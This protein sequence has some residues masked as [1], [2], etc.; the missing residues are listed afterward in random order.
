MQGWADLSD[1]DVLSISSGP[2]TARINPQGAELWSLTDAGDREYMTDADPAFWTGHAPLLFPIVGALNGGRY[3]LGDATYELPRHGFARTR[4]FDVAERRA[5][6]ARFRL[7]D[8]AETRAVYPFAFVLDMAF[9]LDGWTLRMTASVTNPGDTALPFSFGYHPAFAWPLPGGAAKDAHRIR[10]ETAEPGPLRLLDAASGLVVPEPRATPVA[11]Q[12]IAPDAALFAA[13][14]LVWDELA[15]RALTWGAPGGASLAVAF[16]DTP[17]LGL[18][19]KPGAA[20]LCIEPWQG[21][22]DPQG[23]AGDFRDKPGVV[24]LPPGQTRR[25]RMDVTVRPA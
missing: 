25:F 18:W 2:L 9:R 5:D 24:S 3:R 8:D 7:T 13:D 12:E 23:Y 14:A 22:A 16:P 1:A 19:Q 10:F 20:Y 11:G 17:M 4:R 21:H 15:S 6:F